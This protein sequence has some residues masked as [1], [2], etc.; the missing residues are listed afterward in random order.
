MRKAAVIILG[1]EVLVLALAVVVFLAGENDG[2]EQPAS[3]PLSRSLTIPLKTSVPVSVSL[4]TVGMV[5]TATLKRRGGRAVSTTS[6]NADA[7]MAAGRST[8][9]VGGGTSVVDAGSRHAPRP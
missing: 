9:S 7:G 8:V 2:V 6:A 4:A 3:V 5:T 1:L